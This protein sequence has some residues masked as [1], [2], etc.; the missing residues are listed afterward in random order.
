M[1]AESAS[2]RGWPLGKVQGNWGGNV[3]GWI[4]KVLA[5]PS[6]AHMVTGGSICV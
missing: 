3:L 4:F 5:G 1:I 2:A 6:I